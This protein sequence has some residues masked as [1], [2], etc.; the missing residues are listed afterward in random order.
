MCALIL[1]DFEQGVKND[2]TE[3]LLNQFGALT[4]DPE[5]RARVSIIDVLYT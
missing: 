5:K 4:I 3:Q 1:T 2:S